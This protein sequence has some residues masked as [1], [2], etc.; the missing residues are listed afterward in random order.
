MY[1]QMEIEMTALKVTT[2]KFAKAL[3]ARAEWGRQTHRSDQSDYAA[4]TAYFDGQ[5]AE[6]RKSL[7]V[8]AIT[9]L[10]EKTNGRCTRNTITL[11][12]EILDLALEAE[13]KLE[14]AGVPVKLRPGSVY[15]FREAGPNANAYKG[16]MNVSEVEIV[17]VSDGWR[18]KSYAVTTVG[19]KTSAI[20]VITISKAAKLAIIAQA[21]AGF[22]VAADPVTIASPEKVEA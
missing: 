8:A 19:A 20:R 3:A 2:N 9:A 22:A 10:I 21:M 7:D 6:A 4:R 17:R 15:R 12:S 18:L 5:L 14:V 13:K 1:Q 11:F 16:Q